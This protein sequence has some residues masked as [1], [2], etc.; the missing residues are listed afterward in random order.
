MNGIEAIAAA[1][2]AARAA[3]RA[4]LM[5]YFTFG[6]PDPDTS[7][8]IISA[9]ANHSD[10]AVDEVVQCYIHDHTDAADGG[11]QW[12]LREFKRVSTERAAAEH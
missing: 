1:F 10:Q 8:E 3:R 5:P 6:Y 4:A 9:I 2:S 7:L 12:N 11:P